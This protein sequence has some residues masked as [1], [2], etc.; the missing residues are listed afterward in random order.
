MADKDLSA[1]DYLRFINSKA[2]SPICPL[3]R[4][5]AW[6]LIQEKDGK[7]F[8]FQ[9]ANRKSPDLLDMQVSPVLILTCKNCGFIA[10]ILREK[11]MTDLDAIDA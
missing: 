1:E 8:G 6:S 2:V 5:N 7:S 9:Q 11:V 4:T 10:P 3:C